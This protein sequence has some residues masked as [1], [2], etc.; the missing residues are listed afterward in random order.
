MRLA[1]DRTGLL[2]AASASLGVYGQPALAADREVD[3]TYGRIEGDVSLVV[4][5]G[6]VLAPRAPRAEAQI[7]I[8]YLDT[9]GVFGAYEDATVVGSDSEPRRVVITGLELRPL[10][11]ARW[12]SGLETDHA[13]L[14]MVLDSLGLD[15]GATFSQP[16]RGGF[17]SR[18]GLEVGLG[19][20]IPILA[21]ASGPWVDVHGGLRGSEQALALGTVRSTD[22]RYGYLAV[23]LS[24][25]QFAAIHVVDEGDRAP[26]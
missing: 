15:L 22:D 17:A 7:R 6:A 4:G 16:S 13:R 11:L 1:F 26:R 24:W 2:V 14:D 12:L 3:P 10:F 19:V 9:A 8:R 21:T 23:T 25:H 5:A 20:E 18:S